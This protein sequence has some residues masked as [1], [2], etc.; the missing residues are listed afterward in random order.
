M[1]LNLYSDFL[2]TCAG[3]S[4]SFI[5]LLFVALSVV[6][7]N[8][9][10]SMEMEFTDRRLAESAFTSLAVIFF[11]SLCALIPRTNIGYIALIAAFFGV[12][13]SWLLFLHFR[14]NREQHKN[15]PQNKSDRF[16]INVS[17]AVYL[18]LGIDALLTL[19]D[20][21]NTFYIDIMMLILIWLFGIGLLRAWAL[22]GIRSG[23]MSARIL[24]PSDHRTAA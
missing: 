22:T 14:S 11:I 16:W 4:A 9:G 21:A 23:K 10:D 20:P 3:A 19:I 13:G 1:D 12:R 5:G 8:K 2:I 24:N 18:A 6:L 15:R 17:I 7:A